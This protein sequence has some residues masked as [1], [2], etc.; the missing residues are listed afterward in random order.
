M[1]GPSFSY[2]GM[3]RVEPFARI[4][5]GGA[6]TK[7]QVSATFNLP[8]GSGASTATTSFDSGSTS[9]AMG[10]GGG[11]D[12]RLGNGPYRLRII[13]VDYTP[14]FFSDKSIS[15][16]APSGAIQPFTLEGQRADNVRFSFG[17]VF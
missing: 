8:P 16:L 10:V 11:L 13:Q 6:Y 3:K 12:V 9:F 15:V 17:F 2:A 4:L 1:G 14:I 7:H 5:A